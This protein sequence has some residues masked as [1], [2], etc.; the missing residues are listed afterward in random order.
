MMNRRYS[1]YGIHGI[2]LEI[3]T[4]GCLGRRKWNQMSMEIYPEN[5]PDTVFY[6]EHG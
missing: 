5:I 2:S 3:D 4:V 1:F 6:V